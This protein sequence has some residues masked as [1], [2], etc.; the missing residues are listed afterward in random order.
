M[1]NNLLEQVKKYGTPLIEGNQVTFVWQGEN[2][3]QLM[4]DFSD[5]E[6]KPQLDLS[7]ISPGV[8]VY[9]REF[10]DDAYLEYAFIREGKRYPDPFNQRR[11][12][13]GIG[14][15]N[16]FF[17]MPDY[18]PT[19]LT[20]LEKNVTAGKIIPYTL[21][22]KDDISQINRQIYFY[23]PPVD[24]PVPLLYVLD[25]KD[26]YRRA[27]LTN[28]VDNLIAQK[29]IPPIA[30]AMVNNGGKNRFLEYFCSEAT[31]IYQIMTVADR[32]KEFLNLVDVKKEP[33]AFGI[34]GASMGGLMSLYTGMR[35]PEVFG[36]VISLS[37]AFGF[38]FGG[39]DSIVYDLVR[40]K[41][42][43]PLKIWL[44]AGK[45]E[46][47]LDDNRKMK[48]VLEEQGYQITYREYS[49]GHNY[50]A[51]RDEVAFGLESVFGENI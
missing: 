44:N 16:H 10:A 19:T 13:N 15:Y 38:D 35:V 12:P 20:K 9:S 34:L 8:W 24:Q 3:P 46:W 1:S 43:Q 28:I 30:M 6:M 23:Q 36:K 47:L 14:D 32:A 5:W 7:E 25:G 50:T 40:D 26:F 33:G 27:K 18:R 2:P 11:I 41:P 31:L 4:G 29:R 51:W 42:V 45:Y 37:G 17:T 22:K 39:R 48:K 21:A 49:A